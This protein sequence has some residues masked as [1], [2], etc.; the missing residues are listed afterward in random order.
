MS[1]SPAPDRMDTQ[2]SHPSE[3]QP[4]P[5]AP[6]P[7]Q[8]PERRRPK[9]DLTSLTSSLKSANS[10]TAGGAGAGERGAGGGERRKGKSMFGVLVNT[11]NK[12]KNEDRIRSATDAVCPFLLLYPFP[13]SSHIPF[14]VPILAF[15][16]PPLRVAPRAFSHVFSRLFAS[17][18][19]KESEKLTNE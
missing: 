1:P 2:P 18:K 10:S 11:L 3:S 16:A 6:A 14:P 9:L 5:P 4:P 19:T 8:K 17:E 13:H 12:A 15:F 7:A